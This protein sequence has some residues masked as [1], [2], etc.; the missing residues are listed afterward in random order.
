MSYAII[1]NLIA[2][3][4][5]KALELFLTIIKDFDLIIEIG[6]HRGAFSIW[7]YNNKNLNCKFKTFEINPNLIEMSN[8]YKS[9]IDI[10]ITDCFSEEAITDI[11]NLIKT[12][13]KTLLL[14]DGGSKN[15]EFI[16]YSKYLKPN[17]V[18]ML[19]DYSHDN[20]KQKYKEIAIKHNWPNGYES[21]FEV[22]KQSVKDNN[23]QMFL[24]DEFLNVLWGSFIKK[25]IL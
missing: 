12:H 1:D 16:L 14:C 23:L 2:A 20:N 10:K 5:P 21:C 24:Y 18:I 15:E 8:T 13:G 4:V 9:V 22:I 6:T 7:L 19:H 25:E 11:K 3:Q 17:D